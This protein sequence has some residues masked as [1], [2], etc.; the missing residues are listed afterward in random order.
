[1]RYRC[2]TRVIDVVVVKYIR[3][4][5]TTDISVPLKISSAV[6]ILVLLIDVGI[7]FINWSDVAGRLLGLL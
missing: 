1:M 3:C 4:Y 2:S 6:I 5:D 7:V